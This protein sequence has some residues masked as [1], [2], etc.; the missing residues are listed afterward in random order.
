MLARTTVQHVTQD[1]IANTEIMNRIRDYHEKLETLIGDDQYVST[2]YE[3]ERFVNEDV[4]DPREESYEGFREKG[5]EEPYQGYDLSGIDD[6]S[7]D[8]DY[9]GNEDI[10][11]SYLGAESLL[12]DQDGNKKMAKVIKR[13]KGND[14]NPVGTLHNNPMLDTLEYTLEMSDGSSKELTANI[15]AESI[16]TQVD[17]EVHHYQLLQEIPDYRKYL[18][19]ILISDGMIFPRNGNMVPKKTTQVWDLLVECKYGSSSW[20]PL[21][22]LKASNSVELAEYAPGNRLDVEPAFKWWVKDVL[23][24]C[25]IIFA[26]VKAK[27]WRTTHKF[28][29]KVRKYV[30]EALAIDKK[31]GN[32]L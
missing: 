18:S 1:E 11:D 8:T 10:F 12:H 3:F 22:D 15:I 27:Y 16:F 13:V 21:K 24:R 14:G 5:D 28:G 9:C 4:P 2:E 29:I 26:E 31:N 32:T 20:I 17:S 19:S 25:K 23:R 6:F 7:P 30:N